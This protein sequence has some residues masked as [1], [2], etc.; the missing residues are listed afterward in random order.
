M[1]STG[2]RK[3]SLHNGNASPRSTYDNSYLLINQFV[4]YSFLC[5]WYNIDNISWCLIK[6]FKTQII[7]WL[8]TYP[9]WMCLKPCVKEIVW[10]QME[11]N[12]D[13][14]FVSNELGKFCH[15][16]Y[17]S[18]P[19]SLIIFELTRNV[20]RIHWKYRSDCIACIHALDTHIIL[21]IMAKN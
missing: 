9:M 11:I 13:I 10:D 19:S 1:V 21:C 7:E 4:A 16:H 2:Y 3:M 12:I 18:M 6:S 20:W 14:F 15:D 17:S 5:S 8:T